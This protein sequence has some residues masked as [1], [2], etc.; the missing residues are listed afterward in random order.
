[1]DDLRLMWNK[2]SKFM[3]HPNRIL[4]YARRDK[5]TDKTNWVRGNKVDR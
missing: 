2:G 1:M 3:L 5:E 4:Y